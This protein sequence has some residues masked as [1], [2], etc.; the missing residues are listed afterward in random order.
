MSIRW[1]NRSAI[2]PATSY[3]SEPAACVCFLIP[4]PPLRRVTSGKRPRSNQEVFAPGIRPDFVGLIRFAHPAGQPAAVTAL[5]YVSLFH[6]CPR[7]T[8]RRAIPGPSRLS[9]HPCRSTPYTTI[10]LGLLTGRLASSARLAYQNP[11]E[12]KHC[13]KAAMLGLC[14][15]LFVF[16]CTDS[17]GDSV[18]EPVRR[19]S[20]GAVERGVWHGC[21]TRS[22]GPGMAHRDDPRSSAGP[23]GVERSETRMSGALSL[24]LLSLSREQRESDSP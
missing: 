20:G 15:F 21:Q 9:R 7:G 19:P 12:P 23:R 18:F 1:G 3:G 6:H 16:F 5:R 22:D 4:V 8:P 10:P 11:K 14:F 24:W 17:S 2:V 13:C